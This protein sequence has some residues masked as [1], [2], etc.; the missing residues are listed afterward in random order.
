MPEKTSVP[1]PVVVA[2][3]SVIDPKR[4]SENERFASAADF[5]KLVDSLTRA[6]NGSPADTIALHAQRP[7]LAQE[8]EAVGRMLVEL[9][10]VIKEDVD[11][12]LFRQGNA[13][14]TIQDD[15]FLLK[16]RV[17]A[18]KVNSSKQSIDLAP[19]SDALQQLVDAFKSAHDA[20]AHKRINEL[21]KR[22]DALEMSRPVAPRDPSNGC[23]QSLE[24]C[25][26][27]LEQLTSKLEELRVSI[28]GAAR[29]R[30][31]QLMALS[32]PAIWIERS[33]ASAVG[34]VGGITLDAIKEFSSL[35][36]V[37]VVLI[38]V[39]IITVVISFIYIVYL[40][41]Q[42]PEAAVKLLSV[43]V[44][45]TGA[46]AGVTAVIGMP[47]LIS[48][49]FTDSGRSGIQKLP[50]PEGF[51]NTGWFEFVISF[52]VIGVVVALVIVAFVMNRYFQSIHSNSSQIQI[53][54]RIISRRLREFARRKNG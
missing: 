42:D 22:V 9:V 20:D 8:I 13:I 25:A 45:T 16:R 43:F 49:G 53:Y 50:S 5:Q 18:L 4:P 6:I 46:A 26:V 41:F 14:N 51:T 2:P 7:S 17:D 31:N 19:I 44:G 23:V 39:I 34:I 3:T 24:K 35:I 28:E 29:D 52:G 32:R 54:L 48:L 21:A 33:S 47:Y 15:I 27:S 10:S 1:P 37:I 30:H 11:Q 38:V 36:W 40:M 12:A